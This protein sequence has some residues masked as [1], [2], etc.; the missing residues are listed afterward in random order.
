M[1]HARKDYN[2]RVQ[3]S[4]GLI[5]A[6]EP[7]ILIRAQDCCALPAIDAWIDAAVEEHVDGALIGAV[8]LHR[9][10]IDSW[11]VVHGVK[12]PDAPAEALQ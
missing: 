8:Q 1:I 10:L 6:D 11:Q 7:V 3:D 12:K 9:T 4:A 5:P 2:G